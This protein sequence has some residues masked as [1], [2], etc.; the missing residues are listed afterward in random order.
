[1]QIKPASWHRRIAAQ[2]IDLCL[3]ALVL[4]LAARI[5]PEGPPPADS[6]AFFTGQ[7][8]IN[9]FILVALALL[10]TTAA[11]QIMKAIH[12]TPGQRML[13]LQLKTLGGQAPNHKQVNT[14]LITALR[15]ILLIML[16]GPII[17]LVVGTSVAAVLNIPFT[18]TDKLLLKMEIPQ[19]IRYAIHGISFVA[20]LAAVWAVAVRPALAYFERSRGGLTGLDVKSGT[21][22]VYRSDA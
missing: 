9:Y 15:N 11:F 16:P 17:A 12:A 18:T 4:Y 3:L 21:T 10:L 20:L 22:H 19:T 2:A 5:L 1:M 8:F 13:N 7:D 14:R 6:M